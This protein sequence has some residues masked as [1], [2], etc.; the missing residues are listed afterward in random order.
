MPSWKKVIT[1]GSNATLAQISA[2]VVPTA[3]TQNLL[4]IDSSTG[5]IMQITQSGTSGINTFANTGVRTGDGFISGDVGIGTTTPTKKLEVRG[6]ALFSGSRNVHINAAGGGNIRI[7]PPLDGGWAEGYFFNYLNEATHKGGFGGY[8]SGDTLNYFYIG[9]THN[10]NTMVIT[11]GSKRVG[12]NLG[13]TTSP[14]KTLEISTDSSTTDI[15]GTLSGASAGPGVLIRNTNT[16]NNTYANLDFRAHNADGRIAYQYKGTDNEGDFHFI[17][18]NASLTSRMVIQGDGNVG[19]G[20]DSPEYILDIQGDSPVLRIAD[21]NTVNSPSA[22]AIWMGENGANEVRG[23]GIIYDG[24]AN[25]IN[26][27]TSNNGTLTNSN[28]YNAEK[29]LTIQESDGNVGIGTTSPSHMLDVSGSARLGGNE[30]TTTLYIQSTGSFGLPAVASE[31]QMLGYGSRGQGIFFKDRDEPNKEWFA[32]VPYQNSNLTRYQIGYSSNADGQAEYVASASLTIIHTGNVGIG[33]SDPNSRLHIAAPSASSTSLTIEGDVANSKNIFFNSS[34]NGYEAKIRE[35]AGTLG[36]FTGGDMTDANVFITSESGNV[37]IGTTSPLGKLQVNEYTV[38]S[39]GANTA[40]GEASIFANSGDEGLYIGVKNAAYPNRGYGFK[41]TTSGVNSDFTITEHGLSGD[42]FTI[43]SGGNVGIGT[44]TPAQKLHVEG[45]SV[46]HGDIQVSGSEANIKFNRPNGSLVG[47]IGW[48]DNEA[49]YVGG[50]PDYGPEA[51]NLVRVYGF[52]NDL[53]LGNNANG[54][55][56][57]VDGAN[58]GIGTTG[59]GEKLEVVGNISASGDLEARNITASNIQVANDIALGGN[60]FSFNGFSFIEGVSANFSGSNKFGSGSTPG[61]ND[62]AGGGVAHQF[63]G[64]VAITGSGLSI[65]DLANASTSNFVVYNTST[66][67]LTHTNPGLISGS[68]QIASDISG[69]WQGQNFISS[70]GEIASD[71]SGSWQGQ[72]F[73]SSSGEIASDISGSWQG[74]NFISASQ[75]FLSTGQRSGDSAI[76][77]S[78]E[79]SGSGHLTASGN[80]SSSGIIYAQHLSSSGDSNINELTVGK[81]TGVYFTAGGGGFHND[82]NTAV[83][84][85]CL[86]VNTTGNQNTAIG[87]KA[88]RFNSVGR[89]NMALGQNALKNNLSGSSNTA[90]GSGASSTQISGDGNVAIGQS[91]LGENI[92]GS[93][94]I[95][96]G[97]HAGR[98]YGDGDFN[99]KNTLPTSSIFIGSG[100]RAEADFQENQIVIG[101]EA[102]GAGSNSVVLGND[103]I[104]KT[105]LKGNV[106]ASGDISASGNLLGQNIIIDNGDSGHATLGL[107]NV[108]L[109]FAGVIGPITGSGLIISQSFTNEVTHHNMVKIGETELVDISG[110]ITSD[111]FLLNVREKSLVISSSTLDKPVAEI[112]AGQ[113]LFYGS[114]SGQ[115]VIKINNDDLTLGSTDDNVSIKGSEIILNSPENRL[116]A[117]NVTPTNNAH[118]LFS[119]DNPQESS[120]TLDNSSQVLSTPLTSSFPYFGGAVTAS[121]VSSSG[122][123][124]ASLSLDSSALNTVMYNTTT[125]QFFFTGSYGG[126]GGST[127]TATGISGSWQGQNFI[128]SSGEIASDISGS[129]QGQNFISAS[130]TFL[131]TGQ[132]SG[133]SAITGSLELSGSGHLTASGNISA[134]GA[135]HILGGDLTL[136]GSINSTTRIVF[137]SLEYIDTQ[138]G[139]LITNTGTGLLV[140]SHIT[141]SGNISASGHLFASSSVIDDGSP[142]IVVQDLTTGKFHTMNSASIIP[143]SSL[144]AISASYAEVN[145]Q[146]VTDVG[147]TTTNGSEFLKGQQLE[148]AGQQNFNARSGFRNSGGK[149]YTHVTPQL[150]GNKFYLIGLPMN[151]QGEAGSVH[152]YPNNYLVAGQN[153]STLYYDTNGGGDGGGVGDPDVDIPTDGMSTGVLKVNGSIVVEDPIALMGDNTGSLTSSAGGIKISSNPSKLLFFDTDAK[154]SISGSYLNSSASYEIEFNTSSKSL[155]FLAGSTNEDLI[156]VMHISRSGV[157]PRVGIGTNNPLKAFDF[158][159]VS[160][161]SR[162]GE[163]LIRGSRTTKGADVSDEV[164]RINFS[165][166]SSSFNDITTSGSAAEIV[167]LVDEVDTTGVKGHLSFRIANA[168][169]GEPAEIFKLSGSKSILSSPLDVGTLTPGLSD[170]NASTINRYNNTSTRI[171]LQQ[172]HL[173]FYGNA[174][175]LKISNTGIDANPGGLASLDFRV[176]S[177]NDEKAIFVDAGLDSIQLGSNANTH[178]TASGNI[179]SSAASTAS[180]GSLKIDGASVDFSGLP[181]SDPGVAGR[182]WNDSNTLKISAG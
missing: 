67:A 130:Q 64:S 152:D 135:S 100:S 146:E 59:P 170:I 151:I 80:I 32:G 8:G 61:D 36:F 113:T 75:T 27:V 108:G 121:A 85:N 109:E 19:I 124:F 116:R 132:R 137:D 107:H 182:L 55:V 69:S 22:S 31:I 169:I 128:S 131:S 161:D 106:T 114:T 72:N 93:N 122:E 30:S 42:R 35:H 74:Q 110:S 179:S 13:S 145:L 52:G 119:R 20:T 34:S 164:G 112:A 138:N 16:T 91:S 175:G 73:I 155:K 26:L 144:T 160:D 166:D 95:G 2:S 28:P 81:G 94:N 11:S 83:G 47:G 37:G 133:D 68:A 40:H 17:T 15:N 148:Y 39:Q 65:I 78:L 141:A 103:L 180:F 96:V 126:G 71:I 150:Y 165:I 58:V 1:S 60:I 139:N 49:F 86:G 57:I 70:S 51:G 159:S 174:Y 82:T 56:L 79:L 129:W 7:T 127:F 50:H 172:N 10:N 177:D 12:I 18:D 44:T 53:R 117:V 163:L 123:L 115:E 45:D 120:D 142:N 38:A 167:A 136:G 97:Y 104:T 4:A 84:V 147:N 98:T 90:V 92:S 5:G 125:G 105:V 149:A 14:V 3:T 6:N 157:N 41:V 111:A 168:K 101:N 118:L 63:T 77:G 48:D 99:D 43:K 173:E 162:G 66:G 29:R 76:T 156:E 9:Q 134:S 154:K 23:A 62:T 21:N 102:K 54:D 181:T 171:E 87:F 46:F 178:V 140:D 153:T 143:N 89:F 33:T 158:K 88:L 176:R 24:H 25:T